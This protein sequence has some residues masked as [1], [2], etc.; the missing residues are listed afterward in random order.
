MSSLR[1]RGPSEA[2]IAMEL[3][4]GSVQQPSLAQIKEESRRVLTTI[5]IVGVCYFAVSGGPIGS[6]YIVSAGGPLVGF[7]SVLLFP[8]IWGVPI[9]FI[10]AELSTAFPEDG[11]YTVWVLNSF[12]PFW[13]FQTGY[14]SWISGVIDNAIYPALAV[15]TFTDVWG[16]V[17]SPFAEY[18]LKAAIAIALAMPNLLGIRIVGNGMAV[19]SLFVMLPFVVLCIWG[20]V[21]TSDWGV[22]GEVRRED[23][24]TDSEDNFVSMSGAISIDWS[25]LLNT[26]F[27]NFNGAV[28]VSVFGGEVR[29]PGRTYPRAMVI[30]V[31][32]VALSYLVPLFGATAFNSPHWTT[33][34]EGTF[35]SI[36]KAIG[37]GFLSNW[38]VFATFCSNAGM[39]IA[40]LFCDSFQIL[41]MAECGLAP[42]F[43]KQ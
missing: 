34:E 7:I 10:T 11:G 3:E 26:L 18:L 20:M 36:S 41:G 24:V 39:Y 13:A 8:F 30:S 42:A 19:L 28:S 32:L 23:I 16:S 27:W 22:F 4:R 25:L 15:A 43:L 9:A 12:G 37:G 40:E 29:N 5:S 31:V 6:E 1:L 35:S 21:R 14:W 33:W 38:I 17:G 2:S